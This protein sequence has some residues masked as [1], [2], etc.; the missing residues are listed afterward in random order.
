MAAGRS[1]LKVTPRAEFG[2]RASRRLR[3]EGVVPGVV[4]S[5]GAE[6][7]PFQVSERDIRHVL[8]EGAALFDLQIEGSKA[9]PV[10]VKEAQ[11]H[12]VRGS[13]QHLDLFQVDL[14]EEIQAEVAIELEGAES[15]P[16]VKGGGVLEHITREVTV[17]AL[18]TDIPD[19]IVV[20]VSAME[21]NDTLQLTVVTPPDGVKFVAD[22]PEE[23]TIVT[24]TPPRVEE[25]EPEV[26]EEAELVGEGEG[27]EEEGEGAEEAAESG[28]S[29]GE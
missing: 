3:R 10:V 22:E 14:S 6:A 9:V 13:L 11:H 19:R 29:E 7:K 20:D 8:S 25:V 27:A 26:E 2:S 24:L 1:T 16:G 15:S 23:I 18:P 5:G 17:E 28:D 4:Y 21:I 12:P